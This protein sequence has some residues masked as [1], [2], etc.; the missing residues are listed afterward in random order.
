MSEFECLAGVHLYGRRVGAVGELSNGR[1]LFEFDEEY[2]RT[3]LDLSPLKL[4]RQRRSHEFPELR[5]RKAFQGL[6]GVLADALPDDFGRKVLRAFHT[7]RG[8]LEAELSPVQSLLYVGSRA[9]GALEFEPAEEPASR[10][11]D[12]QALKVS[13]LVEGARKVL[14]GHVDD[15]LVEM[16]RVGSSAGGARPKAVILWNPA[17]NEIR[18]PFQ[19]AT[20]GEI[21]AILKFDGV[22][23][24]STTERLGVPLPFNRMEAAY[25]RMARAAGVEVVEV[26]PHYTG[27]GLCHLFIRRFDRVPAPERAGDSRVAKIHQHTFGGLVHADYNNPGSSSYEEL[28]RTIQRL[29]M[30]TGA[31]I[32]AYRRAIFNILAVNQ[33]DHVKNTSFHLDPSGRWTLTPAYDL[34]FAKGEGFTREHQMRFADKTRGFTL[35]DLVSVGAAFGIRN[36]RGIIEQVHEAVLKLPG[37]A[38]A[39]RCDER[40]LSQVTESV[41]LRLGELG[42]PPI[43]AP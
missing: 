36:P 27:D 37:F 31:V 7:S 34:T 29:G 10:L 28:L 26:T 35:D 40:F 25:A 8:R 15:T 1:V 32:E 19:E 4:P 42:L 18:T 24:G 17:T 30:G 3:G 39:T 11:L 33:D 38:E 21:H 13:A 6:P 9:I 22:G 16:Y 2:Q 23:D 12:M 43:R 20:D 5:G 41:N 14:A